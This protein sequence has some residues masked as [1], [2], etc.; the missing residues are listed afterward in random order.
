[1]RLTNEEVA[2]FAGGELEIQNTHEDYLFR[3]EVERVWV[4]GNTM[5]VRFK[6]LAK[7]G[8]DG[9]WYADGKLDYSVSLEIA[10]FS[11]IGKDRLH[12][13]VMYVWERGTFFP[14]DGSKLDPSKVIGL[15][16]A[17]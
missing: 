14:P 1:M 13:Q 9:Q 15:E 5:H 2:R 10:S 7:M 11:D 17:R 8:E 6:W 16:L 12:Y 3:G 4:D